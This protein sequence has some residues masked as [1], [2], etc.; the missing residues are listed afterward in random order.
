MTTDKRNASD[1]PRKEIVRFLRAKGWDIVVAGEQKIVQ[2]PDTPDRVFNYWYV[3]S[4]IG[5]K[6][7]S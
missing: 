4:F 1:S 2:N 5:K 7:K 3:F 6:V